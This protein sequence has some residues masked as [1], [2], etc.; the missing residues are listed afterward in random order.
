[1]TWLIAAYVVVVIAVLGYGLSLASKRRK[2]IS[3][4]DRLRRPR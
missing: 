1:M 3:E 4:I 2:L